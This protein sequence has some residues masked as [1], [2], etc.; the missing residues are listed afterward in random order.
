MSPKVATTTLHG[1]AVI[2]FSN[3][4]VNALSKALC[5]ALEDAASHAKRD[6]GVRAILLVGGDGLPFSGGA[7]I[8]EF[9]TSPKP[10]GS[11]EVAPLSCL[12]QV[13]E[14]AAV[15]VV[16]CIHKY[17]FGGGLELALA[18]HYRVAT[19]DARVGLPEVKLGIIPGAGGTQRLPRLVGLKL[20]LTTIVTGNPVNAKIGHNAGLIDTLVPR[21]TKGEEAL[22]Q[23]ALDLLLQKKGQPLRAAKDRHVPEFAS[24]GGNTAQA[25][26][27]C[28]RVAKEAALKMDK[29]VRGGEAQEGC[30]EAV[31]AAALPH[32]EEG[33]AIETRI[34]DKLLQSD[35]SKARRYVFFSERMSAQNHHLEVEDPLPMRHVGVV[36]G[37]TMGAGIAV[38]FMDA[39]ARVTLVEV[40]ADALARAH[41]VVK[42]IYASRV[43]R[44]QMTQAQAEA[45]ATAGRFQ[46]S[47]SLQDLADTDMVVEAVFE[48]MQLKKD[49]FGKLDQIC[50][51]RT[52]LATNTSTLSIDAIA[53]ATR[54]PGQVLGM[55]FF[56][57]AHLMKLVECVKGQATAPATIAAVA[58]VSK[59]M[60]K[61]CVVVGN[62]NGFVGNRML[63]SYQKEIHFLIEEG[64]DPYRVDKLL[65]DFGFPVGPCVMSDIAGLDVSV[66][67]KQQRK[68]A[69]ALAGVHSTDRDTDVAERLCEDLGRLGQKNLK[70]WYKYD[71]KVGNGRT[72]IPD[73]TVVHPFLEKFR[74][75]KGITPRT[76]ITDQE[77][78]ERSLF[79]L[80]NEGFKVLE[81][82]ISTSGG[83][84]D[85]VWIYGYGFPAFRGGPIYHAETHIGLPKLLAGLER[86]YRQYPHSPHFKPANLLRQ[87]VQKGQGLVARL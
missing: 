83:D 78:L 50:H 42:G 66:R 20:A 54:R 63:F 75:S 43:R 26:E 32:L 38:A 44:G 84:V 34:F 57:P 30:L 48:D 61:V 28:R 55:H 45:L 56:S 29:P 27:L 79:S 2:R 58:K 16:A 60:K 11:N 73:P 53:S 14:S 67:I 52:I 81:E 69:L 22:V 12:I 49:I 5:K 19:A 62:C 35:Q 74:L 17:A 59:A 65:Y 33:L 68:Q 72:P 85:I 87:L 77:I 13:I 10:A 46:G 37:G 80:C 24:L 9:N 82:G 31:A 41:D 7:D 25:L 76:D 86:Y 64:A 1:V 39:G 51:P 21:E 4:P 15:P 71:P 36:G 23:A 8:K 47:L 40:K 6:R 18:C 3:P 70:G